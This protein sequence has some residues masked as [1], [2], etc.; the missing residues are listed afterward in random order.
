MI[1]RT[2]TQQI[3]ELKIWPKFYAAV[4]SGEKT[5]E[6]R[7]N[8]RNYQR[9]DILVMKCFDPENREFHPS[10]PSIKKQIGF[11]LPVKSEFSDQWVILSLL[12]VKS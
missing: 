5:F 1:E 12:E 8:D 3:H 7:F 6:F 4:A 11:I 9:G 2:A 10:L